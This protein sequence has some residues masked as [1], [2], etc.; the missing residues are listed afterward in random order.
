MAWGA[1]NGAASAWLQVIDANAIARALYQ[2]LGF[3]TAY[4]YHYRKRDLE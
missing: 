1:D 4:S 2:R 3:E